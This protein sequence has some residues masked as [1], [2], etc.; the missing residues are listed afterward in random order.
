MKITHSL[1]S[2]T[3][4]TISLQTIALLLTSYRNSLSAYEKNCLTK[5]AILLAESMETEPEGPTITLPCSTIPDA[6][7]ASPDKTALLAVKTAL[8][9]MLPGGRAKFYS[10]HSNKNQHN[11]SQVT[12]L[13][14]T[15]TDKT[16]MEDTDLSL[17]CPFDPD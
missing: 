11:I 17:E 7:T 4:T 12:C 15:A 3:E 6:Y 16:M 10:E 9:S 5:F 1:L 8:Y 2:R 14:N 13:R